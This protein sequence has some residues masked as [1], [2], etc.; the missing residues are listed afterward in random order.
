MIR[1]IIIFKKSPEILKYFQNTKY[2]KAP[3]C[4]ALFEDKQHYYVPCFARSVNGDNAIK[5]LREDLRPFLFKEITNLIYSD[6]IDGANK[7]DA[8]Y[9]LRLYPV[10]KMPSI[11]ACYESITPDISQTIL[12]ESYFALDIDF[13]D[14]ENQ[15]ILVFTKSYKHKRVTAP[16]VEVNALEKQFPAFFTQLESLF[17]ALELPTS[18]NLIQIYDMLDT[19]KLNPTTRNMF[20]S[21]VSNRSSEAARY[22]VSGNSVSLG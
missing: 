12:K 5:A 14:A 19:E 8:M 10:I 16:S 22:P 17:E 18:L 13:F 9:Q 3:A 15:Q 2:F 1:T 11:E 4:I 20:F 6:A 7:S 21:L